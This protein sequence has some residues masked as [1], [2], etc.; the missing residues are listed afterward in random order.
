MGR[1]FASRLLIERMRDVCF[2]S[3][4]AFA[5]TAAAGLPRQDSHDEEKNG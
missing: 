4:L 1:C 3:A 2:G 5:A